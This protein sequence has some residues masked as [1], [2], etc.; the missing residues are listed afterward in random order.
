M[1][2]SQK[3]FHK[4][5]KFFFLVVSWLLARLWW[6]IEVSRL[7]ILRI[8]PKAV[9][10]RISQEEQKLPPSHWVFDRNILYCLG[11]NEREQRIVIKQS[12][13]IEPN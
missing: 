3:D 4:R 9:I 12:P 6:S 2:M 11:V 1:N 5:K 13:V 8:Q 7:T 10:N